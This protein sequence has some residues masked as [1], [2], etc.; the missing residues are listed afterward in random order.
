MFGQLWQGSSGLDMGLAKLSD[1]LERFFDPFLPQELL[2]D[3]SNR[4]AALQPWRHCAVNWLYKAANK[5]RACSC[6]GAAQG[7]V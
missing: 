6:S 3:G 5:P 4:V 2:Q 7:R 1:S